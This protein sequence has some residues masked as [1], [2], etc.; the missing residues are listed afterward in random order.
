MFDGCFYWFTVKLTHRVELREDNLS[1]I[2]NL[3]KVKVCTCFSY[4]LI[5][6]ICHMLILT[7][8]LS[9]NEMRIC[10]VKDHVNFKIF[11]VE[12]MNVIVFWL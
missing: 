5:N 12:T 3:L 2:W 1:N 6:A 8:L 9:V 11:M 7:F 4:T 10:S